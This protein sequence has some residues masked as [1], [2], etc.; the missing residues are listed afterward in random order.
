MP[1]ASG[2]GPVI[3]CSASLGLTV[4]SSVQPR[5]R[6]PAARGRTTCEAHSQVLPPDSQEVS[7]CACKTQVEAKHNRWGFQVA[8]RLKR[9]ATCGGADLFAPERVKHYAPHSYVAGSK[10][11][12]KTGD[13]E[14]VAKQRHEDVESTTRRLVGPFVSGKCS[15]LQQLEYG[16]ECL[17]TYLAA[18]DIEA[19]QWPI[20]QPTTV[21]VEI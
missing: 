14:R 8:A 10:V 4:S 2:A 15:S 20:S 13:E 12:P 16:M 17:L 9:S 1:V 5:A 18:T 7:V 3:I 11:Q 21:R 19:Q 6:Q